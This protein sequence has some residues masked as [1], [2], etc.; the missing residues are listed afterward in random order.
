MIRYLKKWLEKLF[1]PFPRQ[2]RVST[3]ERPATPIPVFLAQQ[4]LLQQADWQHMLRQD[5]AAAFAW[6]QK[7]AKQD[8]SE[9]TAAA[10]NMLG[11][12]YE[13]GWGV[14]IDLDKAFSYYVNASTQGDIW[15]LF[16]LA[17]CYRKGVGCNID[18]GRAAE[19]YAQA[20]AKNHVKALN[21][22]GLCYEE[23][24]GVEPDPEKAAALFA[25][26]AAA[27]D[28]WACLNH[29]RL[30]A[31][32]G[33]QAQSLIWLERSLDY[34]SGDYCQTFAALFANHKDETLR[35]LAMRAKA[36]MIKAT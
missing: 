16:N 10:L 17:D 7:A 31:T 20:A 29:A 27:G 35:H 18:V 36:M 33:E 4:P 9:A 1:V 15:A 6:F 13:H 30:L 34:H 11:R 23:G 22:L 14:D 2:S 28:C 3:A 24:S 21:M 32:K 25:Q 8:R 12:C 5:Q 26:G 19:C